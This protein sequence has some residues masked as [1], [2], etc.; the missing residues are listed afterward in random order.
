MQISSPPNKYYYNNLSLASGVFNNK[1]Y[2][3]S[4]NSSI[5]SYDGNS[6]TYVSINNPYDITLGNYVNHGS[7][8]VNNK[9]YLGFGSRLIYID[10]DNNV[11]GAGSIP[12]GGAGFFTPTILAGK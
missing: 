3:I 9:L 2:Y 5:Y 7:V 8:V 4:Y 12:T 11:F 6:Y 1:I 10:S